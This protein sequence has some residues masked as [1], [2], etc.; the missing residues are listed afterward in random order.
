[1]EEI[2][3][4][5]AKR[6]LELAA[7]FVLVAGLASPVLAADKT[8][9]VKFK[10]GSNSATLS[11][12]IKGNDG[13]RYTL[14]ARAGQVMS[15]VFKPGNASCY[16]NVLPPGSETEAIFI[17][18]TEGN[19]FGGTL[20]ADGKYTVQVYLMRNAARRGETCKY[21]ITFKI[22]G[23]ANAATPA[24]GTPSQDE[25]A[26]LQAVST[27]TGNGEVVLLRTE[28]SEANNAV[29]VGV[30]P[31]RAEWRCLVKGGV[32]AEVMSMTDEGAL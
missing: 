16:F 15:V 23:S 2:R 26:C 18:S 31:N 19:A 12:S 29:Y 30:G 21:S 8:Q 5:N 1:M 17:G 20:S 32:V 10:S 25:Q 11:G 14:G 7:S 9:A 13:I 27:Q 28:T 24:A 22:A 3:M 4:L 6:F